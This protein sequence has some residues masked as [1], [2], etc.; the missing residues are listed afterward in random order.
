MPAK[1]A[2]PRRWALLVLVGV[3]GG[4]LSG[5]FGVGGGAVMVPLLA[6]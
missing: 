4:V 2:S 1:A 5:F 3:L 6:S